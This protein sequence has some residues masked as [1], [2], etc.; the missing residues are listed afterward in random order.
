MKKTILLLLLI[1]CNASPMFA[2][3]TCGDQQVCASLGEILEIDKVI[4]ETVEHGRDE[5]LTSVQKKSVNKKDELTNEVIFSAMQV[6][7]KTNLTTPINI[8]ADFMELTHDSNAYSFDSNDLIFEPNNRVINNPVN[9]IVTDD[10]VPKANIRPET[11][12]GNYKGKVMFT[13]GAI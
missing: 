5:D 12:V 2:I 10:F 13:L 8:D 7:I 1:I 4:V 9:G 3:S 6:K 11:L